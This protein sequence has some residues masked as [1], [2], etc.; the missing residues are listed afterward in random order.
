MSKDTCHSI[1][2]CLVLVGKS[3]CDNEKGLQIV[4]V[5]CMRINGHWLIGQPTHIPQQDTNSTTF[6][7][8]PSSKHPSWPTTTTTVCNTF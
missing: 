4:G 3:N 8:C 6:K 2:P 1:K 7:K 5:F